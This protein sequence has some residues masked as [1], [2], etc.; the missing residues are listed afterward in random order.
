MKKENLISIFDTAKLMKN[1]IAIEVTI[2]GQET[3]E[4]IINRYEN[5]D[6]KLEFYTK[7]YDENCVHCMNNE[8]KIVNAWCVNFFKYYDKRSGEIF[9]SN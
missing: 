4:V 6:N 8:V 2:P 9:T 1:D 3:T 7:A 5:L